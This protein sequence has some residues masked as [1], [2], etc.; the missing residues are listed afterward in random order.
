MSTRFFSAALL[1]VALSIACGKPSDRAARSDSAAGNV[2]DSTK[3]VVDSAKALSLP[4]SVAAVATHGET[5]YDQVKAGDWTKAGAVLDSLDAAVKTLPPAEPGIR[6]ERAKLATLTDTLRR[7][8]GAK[9]KTAALEASNRVTYLAAK[10]TEPYHPMEPPAVP[11]LDYYGRELE[12]WSA[13]GNRAKL[14]STVANI[15]ET[16]EGLRPQ[17]ESHGGGPVA[18]KTDSLVTLI[19]AAK[20]PAEQG[21]LAKPFLDVVDELEK[22]FVKPQ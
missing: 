2:S 8:V 16:W 10:M 17:V 19:V 18:K 15:R 14:K 11:L 13:Q 12:I 6:E 4:P 9:N 5:L 7:T 3:A 20:T 21:K 22:V 1:L